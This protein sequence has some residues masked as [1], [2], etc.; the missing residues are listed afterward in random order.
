MRWPLAITPTCLQSLYGQS[1]TYGTDQSLSTLAYTVNCPCNSGHEISRW[2]VGYCEHNP[3]SQLCNNLLIIP[4]MQTCCSSVTLWL[5]TF[6]ELKQFKDFRGSV[7]TQSIGSKW[8][9]TKSRDSWLSYSRLQWSLSINGTGLLNKYRLKVN[10]Q[11]N[12]DTF[13]NGN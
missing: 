2:T 3:Q 13:D 7:A 12:T 5:K 11:A 4:T 8:K 10:K 6:Q 9:Q 1:E